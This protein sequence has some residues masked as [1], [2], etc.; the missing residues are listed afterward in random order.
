MEIDKV[1]NDKPYKL[2]TAEKCYTHWRVK[3]SYTC[4]VETLEEVREIMNA[5]GLIPMGKGYSGMQQFL[6]MAGEVE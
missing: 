6:F 1:P 3:I 5:E 4:N 2:L